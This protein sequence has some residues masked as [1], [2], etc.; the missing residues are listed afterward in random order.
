MRLNE[1]NLFHEQ[2]YKYRT[3]YLKKRLGENKKKSIKVQFQSRQ[4]CVFLF[5]S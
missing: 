2:D 3:S 1:I 4:T 5:I